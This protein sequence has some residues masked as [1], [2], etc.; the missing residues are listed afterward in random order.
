MGDD[1]TGVSKGAQPHIHY[2]NP[3]GLC[4]EYEALAIG[5][6]KQSAKTYL[7]THLQEFKDASLEQL[8]IHS[9]KAL[10]SSLQGDQELDEE[11]VT[12][13][14]VGKGQKF[15]ILPPA[16]VKEYLS[17]FAEEEEKEEEKEGMEIAAGNA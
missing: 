12:V 3:A 13:A 5:K 15:K 8:V 14:V 1:P 6:R 11:N 16:E 17:V 10:R 4:Q 7:E 2:I 9:L